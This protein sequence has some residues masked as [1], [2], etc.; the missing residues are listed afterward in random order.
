MQRCSLSAMFPQMMTVHR[1]RLAS[2]ATLMLVACQ[3][4][5][6]KDST[7]VVLEGNVHEVSSN[8]GNLDTDIDESFVTEAG[9]QKGSKFLFTCNGQTFTA[10]FGTTYEDVAQGDWVGFLRVSFARA[11]PSR[12]GRLRK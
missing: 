8:H 2:L 5:G 11:C 1:A 10:T 7:P 9:L 4:A 6:E 3:S 12:H